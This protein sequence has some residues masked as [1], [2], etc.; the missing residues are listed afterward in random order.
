MSE[1]IALDLDLEVPARPRYRRPPRDMSLIDALLTSGAVL[2]GGLPMLCAFVD[3][4]L[5]PARGARGRHDR[6]RRVA[7]VR[8][9]GE[10]L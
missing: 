8:P 3:A 7:S 1:Q 10:W 9:T 2:G 5:N 4:P 6:W